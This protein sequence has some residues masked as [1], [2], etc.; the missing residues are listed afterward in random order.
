MMRTYSTMA[1]RRLESLA[2]QGGVE[3]EIHVSE[4]QESGRYFVMTVDFEPLKNPVPLGFTDEEAAYSI[5]H[6]SVTKNIT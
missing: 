2:R 1:T 3:C 4:A 6:Q 5:R